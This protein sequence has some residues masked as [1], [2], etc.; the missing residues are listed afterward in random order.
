VLLDAIARSDGTR[1]SV[2]HALDT[3]QLADGVLGPLV[4]DSHGEPLAQPIT[5][6]RAEH[7]GG[8][9]DIVQGLDGTVPVDVIT[10]S[11][12]LVG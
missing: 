4:L 12:R 3:T 9:S 1:A 5:V 8:R 6:V 10:P 7:S 2:A 11:K